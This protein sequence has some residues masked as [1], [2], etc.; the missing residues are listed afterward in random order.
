MGNGIGKGK[1]D[2]GDYLFCY[3]LEVMGW[4]VPSLKKLKKK[5]T[6]H[7]YVSNLGLKFNVPMKSLS[8]RDLKSISELEKLWYE[9]RDTSEKM[10][11]DNIVDVYCKI[12]SIPNAGTRIH[13]IYFMEVLGIGLKW[14]EICIVKN[15]WIILIEKGFLE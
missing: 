10:T 14:E 9:K 4:Y 11:D 8:V 5:I 6:L 7:K 15:E 1:N 12:R 2:L 3:H 13:Q